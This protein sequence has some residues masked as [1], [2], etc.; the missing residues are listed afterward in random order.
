MTKFFHQLSHS[1]MCEWVAKNDA[2]SV[3]LCAGTSARHWY[4]HCM[5][6]RG[7]IAWTGFT[8]HSLMH[9]LCVAHA[10]NPVEEQKIMKDIPLNTYTTCD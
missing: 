3:T 8:T 6:N 10:E 7:V 9:M 1:K 5:G 4:A 2:A